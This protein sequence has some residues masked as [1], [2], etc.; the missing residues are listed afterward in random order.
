MMRD[1]VDTMRVKVK[2]VE[3]PY[4]VL[5]FSRGWKMYFGGVFCFSKMYFSDMFFSK[6]L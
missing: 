5:V 3:L 4:Y 6:E 2:C 1:F